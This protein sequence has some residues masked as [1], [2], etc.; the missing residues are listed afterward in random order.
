MVNSFTLIRCARNAQLLD[1]PPYALVTPLYH[2][3]LKPEN[4]EE[5]SI[6]FQC[7]T[8]PVTCV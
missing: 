4:S 2:E 3:A 6:A 5:E 7:V 1:S 8:N